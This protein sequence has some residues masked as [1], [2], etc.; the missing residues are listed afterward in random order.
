M[1]HPAISLTD[2]KEPKH[3]LNENEYIQLYSHVISILS[4]KY[5]KTGQAHDRQISNY[6]NIFHYKNSVIS[7]SITFTKSYERKKFDSSNEQLIGPEI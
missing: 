3:Q 6:K 7:Y 4:V 2:N 1:H 5:L